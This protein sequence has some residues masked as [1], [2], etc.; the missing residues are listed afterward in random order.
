MSSTPEPYVLGFCGGHGSSLQIIAGLPL[1]RLP[2]GRHP[3]ARVVL[4]AENVEIE[5]RTASSQL[6]LSNVD[7]LT[8]VGNKGETALPAIP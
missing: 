6:N 5:L 3:P 7:G 2:P 1:H 8:L 4:W